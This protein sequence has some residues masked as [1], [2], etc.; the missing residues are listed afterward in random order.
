MAHLRNARKLLT[1]SEIKSFEPVLS[2]KLN[3]L[4]EAQLK[5]KTSLARKNVTKYKMKARKQKGVFKKAKGSSE[6]AV[7]TEQKAALFQ[8]ILDRLQTQLSKVQ[9]LLPKKAKN[10]DKA[11]PADGAELISPNRREKRLAVSERKEDAISVAK[12]WQK[13]PVRRI[14]GFQGGRTRRRQGVRDHRGP[15]IK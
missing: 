13:T 7:R 6:A 11:L 14:V 4:T 12:H 1:Q 15:T 3:A 10:F 9:K 8:E 5:K 2:R